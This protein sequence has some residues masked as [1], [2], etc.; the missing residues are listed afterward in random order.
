MLERIRRKMERTSP[1]NRQDKTL[2]WIQ[3]Q[4]GEFRGEI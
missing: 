4:V 3:V 2:Q 1:E